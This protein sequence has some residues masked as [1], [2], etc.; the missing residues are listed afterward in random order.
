MTGEKIEDLK[1]HYKTVLQALRHGLEVLEND[2]FSDK[3]KISRV[4]HQIK[5]AMH[6]LGYTDD[7]VETYRR[8]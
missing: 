8:A 1:P 3:E 5:D 7:L 4:R 2:A 6:V